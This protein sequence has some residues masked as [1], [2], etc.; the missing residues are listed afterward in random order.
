VGSNYTQ[1][2]LSPLKST[3]KKQV[4]GVTNAKYG[5][6]ASSD[7]LINGILPIFSGI[8]ID[9]YGPSFGSLASSSFILLGAIVRAIGGQRSSFPMWVPR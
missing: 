1:S 3:I 2:S 9:Y 7:Q 8:I 5:V 4:P 6:I